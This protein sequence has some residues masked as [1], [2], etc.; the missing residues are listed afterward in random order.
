LA[1]Y[2][3]VFFFLAILAFNLWGEGLRRFLDDSRLNISRIFSRTTVAAFAVVA[4]GIFAVVQSNAPLELY[5]S[6]ATKFD[7]S[8]VLADIRALASPEMQ[9]RETGTPGAKLAADYIAKQ[10]KDAGLYPAGEN[11]TFFQATP[12]PRFHLTAIPRLE[13]L[14]AANAPDPFTY[15]RD[16]VEY[17]TAFP[18]YGESEGAIIGVALGPDSGTNVSDP[19]S[20]SNLNLR[21][22]IIVVR[23]TD[24]TRLNLR[25]VAGALLVTD[26][27]SPFQHKYLFPTEAGL[28]P[29]ARSR[30]PV[31]YIGVATA[32]KL[33]GTAGSTLA[34][35]DEAATTLPPGKA[36]LTAE[37][38]TV[39]MSINGTLSDD[40]NEKYYQVIGYL[41]GTAALTPGTKGAAL[42]SRV[43]MVSAYYDGL[44]TGPDGTLYPGANDNASSV[45]T[46]LELARQLK[47]SPYQP[48]KT[49][50]FVAWSGGE[51]GESLSVFNIMNAKVGFPQ[52]S[53]EAVLELSGVGA[54]SG[55]AIELG[56]GSSFKLV[57]LFQSAAD[58]VGV[59]TTTRGRGPHFGLF[60]RN[61]FG[62]R[63]ALTTYLS[64]DGSDQTAHTASD[65]VETIDPAKLQ[66]VGQTMLLALSVLTRE[67]NY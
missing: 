1:W 61:S 53:V 10:M 20:L 22:K 27:S 25:A 59:A 36:A 31:M 49:V 44:G 42:D 54:G 47:A 35:L 21:D 46:M 45:A 63:T 37:G 40:I 33:L 28:N 29:F 62:E 13:I 14:N 56:Q 67:V 50:V 34:Q 15:R 6:E 30:A 9:G 23:D 18:T 65:T 5:R 57:Q 39:H 41:P 24:I 17:V 32:N 19:F 3:G 12:S 16:F 55:N 51:R 26:D 48:K 7:A 52:L 64:W 2:P 66:K 38:A 58:R 4:A 11:D 8:R 43:I 60:A